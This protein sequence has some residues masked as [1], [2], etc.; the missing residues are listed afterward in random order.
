LKDGLVYI[1]KDGMCFH[2]GQDPSI[3]YGVDICNHIHFPESCAVC[4]MIAKHRKRQASIVEYT[5]WKKENRGSKLQERETSKDR[6][7]I[8]E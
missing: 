5:Q 1:G 4:E 3:Y 6:R 7:I 2:C 8:S